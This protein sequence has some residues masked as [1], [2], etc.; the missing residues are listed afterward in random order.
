MKENFANLVKEIDMQFQETQR[1]PNKMDAMR[2]TPRHIIIRKPKFKD[3]ERLLKVAKEKKLIIYTGVPIK[4]SA[5][6]CKESFQARRDW[7]GIFQVMKS[8]DL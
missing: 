2:P 1:V 5:D 7:Q 6:F 8:R 3:K 4:L